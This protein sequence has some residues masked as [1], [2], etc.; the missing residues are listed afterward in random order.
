MDE[1]EEKEGQENEL[2]RAHVKL[3]MADRVEEE[4]ESGLEEKKSDDCRLVNSRPVIG[5]LSQPMD[6]D[7]SRNLNSSI[8]APSAPL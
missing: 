2:K 4:F 7:L 6:F 8:S 1:K 3:E 5:V